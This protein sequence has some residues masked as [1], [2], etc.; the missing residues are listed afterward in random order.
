MKKVKQVNENPTKRNRG[1]KPEIYLPLSKEQTERIEK[2]YYVFKSILRKRENFLIKAKIIKN[3]TEV[4]FEELV[5]RVARLE[6]GHAIA[7]MMRYKT[8]EP[9]GEIEVPSAYDLAILEGED[10][11]YGDDL[12]NDARPCGDDL[13]GMIL[14]YLKRRFRFEEAKYDSFE[15][16]LLNLDSHS[17]II[18]SLETLLEEYSDR[19]DRN[20]KLERETDAAR[21]SVFIANILKRCDHRSL[22]NDAISEGSLSRVAVLTDEETPLETIS[23]GESKTYIPIL[24]SAIKKAL[25][26]Q[27]VVKLLMHSLEK[28]A[29]KGDS[30]PQIAADVITSKYVLRLRL[31]AARVRKAR[32]Q[33]FRDKK[34]NKNVTLYN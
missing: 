7:F 30:G 22:I 12:S 20:D 21:L 9:A 14:R 13:S 19:L 4:E 25:T 15:A 8:G 29:V 11:L 27:K 2:I 24:V 16:G 5:Q 34:P 6:K 18:K 17:K 1:R 3:K 10:F 28:G 31:S 32:Q 23:W 33:L 26:D